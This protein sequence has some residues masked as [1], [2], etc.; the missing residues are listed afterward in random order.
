[1]RKFFIFLI[2][3][4]LFT[5]LSSYATSYYWVGGSGDWSDINHWVTTS[6]GTVHHIQTPTSNDNVIFD[7]SSGSS[8]ITINL[9]SQTIFCRDF[10]V[11]NISHALIFNGV[12]QIMKV[13]GGMKL[14]ALFSFSNVDIYFEALS[15]THD[16]KSNSII[17]SPDMYFKGTGN[18]QIID[19]LRCNRIFLES[20]SIDVL[21]TSINAGDFNSDGNYTRSIDLGNA[22][23]K[24]TK[25]SVSGSSYSANAGT[26]HI[27]IKSF[28]SSFRHS[29]V[30]N[31]V[32]YDLTFKS[33]GYLN[34]IGMQTT[35]HNV[36]F[37]TD[38]GISGNN[39][40]DSL[41]F[42]FGGEYTVAPSFTQTINQGLYA[43]GDCKKY[44]SITS[45]N[46]F[47]TFVKTNGI[48][49]CDYG[50]LHHI[51]ANGGA[52][53]IA[54]GSIDL[55]DNIGWQ[56]QAAPSRDLYWVSDSGD[57]SDTIHWSLTSGGLGGECIPTLVDNV[58][59]DANS[60]SNINS[61]KNGIKLDIDAECHDFNWHSNVK[62]RMRLIQKWFISGSSF[63]GNKMRFTRGEIYYVSNDLG[64]TI[65]TSNIELNS[66][67]IIFHG[68]GSWQ[69]LDSLNNGEGEINH[70]GGHLKTLGEY[71]R[72]AT[73]HSENN[74]P[75]ELSFGNSTIDIS[76][77]FKLRQDSLTVHPNTS[78]IRM[79]GDSSLF[80][81]EGPNPAQLYNVTFVKEKGRGFIFNFFTRFNK[82]NYFQDMYLFGYAISDT[83]YYHKGKDYAFNKR[84]DSIISFMSA[85]ADCHHSISL[86]DKTGQ[87]IFYINM[88]P[89]AT[90]DVVYSN[91]RGS[92]ITGATPYIA[93]NSGD[94]GAN[95]GW[96]FINTSMN[97]YWVAGPGNWQ[98]S[99]HWSYSS[100]GSSGACIPMIYDDVFFDGNSFISTD[101]SVMV[102]S[103]NIYCKNM[104]WTN[105]TNHP[106][107]I[108]GTDKVHY[109]SGSMTLIDNMSFYNDGETFFVWEQS[110]KTIDM[111][112]NAFLAKIT[113]CDSGQWTLLD[114][115][116]VL[117]NLIHFKGE[118]IA[119]QFLISAKS[120]TG[121]SSNAKILNIQ[122]SEFHILGKVDGLFSWRET[123]STNIITAGSHIKF[124][125]SGTLET[126]GFGNTIYHNVSFV[127]SNLLGRVEHVNGIENTF[128]RLFFKSDGHIYGK[129][130]FDTLIFSKGGDYHFEAGFHQYVG[131][132]WI[133]DA[134]CYGMINVTGMSLSASGTASTLHQ[135]NGNVLLHSVNLRNLNAVGSGTFTIVDGN[136]L[137]GNSS[138]WQIIPTASRILYWVNEGGD[139]FDTTHWSLATGGIGGECIPTYKDD[140][141][142]DT[143]SFHS[144]GEVALAV[145]P[146][147]CHDYT[148]RWTPN[149]PEL[150]MDVLNIYGSIRLGDTMI[151]NPPEINMY[152]QDTSNYIMTS[153]QTVKLINFFS[154]GGWRLADDIT[155]IKGITHSRGSFSSK[156]YGITANHYLSNSNFNRSIDFKNS[157]INLTATLSLNSTNLSFDATNSNIS[158]DKNG[159]VMRLTVSGSASLHFNEVSFEPINKYLSVVKNASSQRQYYNKLIINNS[160]EMWGENEIDSLI[161]RAGNTYKLE[162]AITQYI[163][164][165]WFVRGNNCNALNLQSTKKNY[166]AFVN[167]TSGNVSGDFINMRDISANGGALYYAG[168]YSTDIS[169]NSGWIF[170]NGPQY[171]Y[172]LGPD[173]SFTLGGTFTIN[174]SNFNGGPNTT[175]LWSDGSTNSS[176]VV[177]K[178]GWYYVS[179]TFTGG[180][181]VTDSI[182]IGC[183]LIMNYTVTDNPCNGDSLG[184]IQAQIPDPNF[185]YQYFWSTGDTL[186]FIDSLT[187]GTYYITVS[188]DSG[189]CNVKDTLLVIEPLPVICPQGDT[190]FCI[191]DS[192]QLDLGFFDTYLWND[193]YNSQFR[194]VS[195]AD[196]F[197]ISVEDA[198]GC[199]SVPDT[200]NIREDLPPIIDLGADTT[201]CLGEYVVLDAGD[202]F[203]EY[204]W[205]ANSSMSSV[206]VY[207][208][209]EYWVRVREK[210]CVVSDT[211]ELFNCPPK[212]I[213]PNVFTPNGDGYNDV[214]NIEYQNIWEFQ[215][216]IYDRWGVKV[217]QS[218]NLE[219]PW[220]GTVNGQE[221]AEGVYFWQIIYQ[222]YNGKGGGYED[223]M[224][225]GTISL[226]R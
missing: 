183:D 192:V 55:G 156:S 58:I 78:H 162:E 193:G 129:N 67:S 200:I 171:V 102:D 176:L 26:S 207:Y 33:K 158:F 127:D 29:F 41:I 48:V 189:L 120:Y 143:A 75:T 60:F 82:L 130:T 8:P 68:D 114:T 140:V 153:G 86:R 16:I 79:I 43:E 184:N 11:E 147:E 215:V 90:L 198:D 206:K 164:D 128:N 77:K 186:D 141:F 99:A 17:I 126:V 224:Q 47:A 22:E 150:K 45:G 83:V 85:H 222:E 101:D 42:A 188:A 69:L 197:I 13:Y 28:A 113:F 202:G 219:N 159:G 3:L 204:L 31:Q 135:L 87:S 166:T 24:V 5:S 34:S 174:T 169:N 210:T 105:A 95:T 109:I 7:G 181:T 38:G 19:N 137:G 39:I 175:Y 97:H 132:K 138:N 201:I 157:Q 72:A 71:V 4:L 76:R 203:D 2:S 54:S 92:K 103:M 18:W 217:H 93:A 14:S 81:T 44:I 221:A 136:D 63:F 53:F 20:G 151:T 40:Y 88:G 57:W 119:N 100:G 146:I 115:L 214:F 110:G 10:N 208:T 52:S 190:A 15:G 185:Y 180:C 9:N 124:Y 89:S 66:Q 216:K 149:N 139:W 51:H 205:S 36:V 182:Y 199:W 145:S 65:E 84:T 161:F 23:I 73:F 116:V 30:G 144:T 96:S 220:D 107:F 165:Y 6:G 25:W 211:I 178:T 209:G 21:S 37:Q 163:G 225:Q 117:D 112:G 104:D 152:A 213:V 167:K 61:V 179:V 1:M 168:S 187:A 226:F 59:V 70:K 56:I 123:G 133:A 74:F 50:I 148:W 223:K 154:D 125:G 160:A 177:N 111:A 122:N 121:N 98:D 106:R 194:W 155:L 35:F 94:L 172:G 27:I 62:G 80:E 91:I 191:E 32:Y 142:F 49:N 170:S 173:T 46:G 108:N 64:E 212:F 134:D 12:C 195:Q 218:V 196:S 131:H 118:L